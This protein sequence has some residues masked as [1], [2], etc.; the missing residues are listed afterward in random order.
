[1]TWNK[2]KKVY[3]QQSRTISSNILNSKR[4]SARFLNKSSENRVKGGIKNTISPVQKKKRKEKRKGD[5]ARQPEAG[6]TWWKLIK[7]ARSIGRSGSRGTSLLYR[8]NRKFDWTSPLVWIDASPCPFL[9]ASKTQ[10]LP[11]PLLTRVPFIQCSSIW[12]FSP[13]PR[14]AERRPLRPAATYRNM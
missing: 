11:F 8:Q 2:E 1:M 6:G 7:K 12:S 9:L 5:K 14:R 13:R 3:W 10:P 4:S